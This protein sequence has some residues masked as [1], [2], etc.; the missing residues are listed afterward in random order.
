[1]FDD[2]LWLH[3]AVVVGTEVVENVDWC[4]TFLELLEGLFGLYL[5]GKALAAAAADSLGNPD[6]YSSVFPIPKPFLI[7][8][9]VAS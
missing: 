5:D 2:R 3:H 7:S 4:C 6:S 9:V 1:M 8:P